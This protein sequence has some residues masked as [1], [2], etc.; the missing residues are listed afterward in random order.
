MMSGTAS[1]DKSKILMKDVEGY[2]SEKAEQ[3]LPYLKWILIFMNLGRLII[4]FTALF[5]SFKISRVVIYYESLYMMVDTFLPMDIDA[6]RA[7]L[8][9]RFRMVDVLYGFYISSLI[10]GFATTLPQLVQLVIRAMIL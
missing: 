9:M 5:K 6:D 1:Y 10:E 3:M 7:N 8:V 2:Q 4:I